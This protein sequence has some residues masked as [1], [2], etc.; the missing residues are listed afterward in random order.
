[1]QDLTNKILRD[2][3]NAAKAGDLNEVTRLTSLAEKA[4]SIEA[5][6]NRAQKAYDSFIAEIEARSKTKRASTNLRTLPVLVSKGMI[7]QNLLTLTKHVKTGAIRVGEEML[8]ETKPSGER[9]KT[10][11][12]ENGNRLRERGAIGRFYRENKVTPSSF[13]VLREKEKNGVWTLELPQPGEF[14]RIEDLF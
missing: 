5:D 12:I 3:A 2:V 9:F 4:R 6:L 1:M 10:D 8:I 7:N 14:T 11:L 13:V